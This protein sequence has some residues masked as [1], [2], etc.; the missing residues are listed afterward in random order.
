MFRPIRSYIFDIVSIILIICVSAAEALYDINRQ[1]PDINEGVLLT[2]GAGIAK[3]FIPY[4]DLFFI[5]TP[6]AY[7]WLSWIALHPSQ[8]AFAHYV[9]AVVFVLGSL[10]VFVIG[11]KIR[12]TLTGLVAALLVLSD[13]FTLIFRVQLGP[14]NWLKFFGLVTLACL[15]VWVEHHSRKWL[16]LAGAAAAAAFWSFQFGALAVIL[17]FLV[18]IWNN[19]KTRPPRIIGYQLLIA[20]AGMLIVSAPFLTYFAVNNVMG[21]FVQA[22]IG[23]PLVQNGGASGMLD[24]LLSLQSPLHPVIVANVYADLES[25]LLWPVF[26]LY[27]IYTGWRWGHNGK[28]DKSMLLIVYFSMFYLAITAYEPNFAQH[29]LPL[30]PIMEVGAAS[31]IATVFE[32][33]ITWLRALRIHPSHIFHLRSNLIPFISG[34]LLLSIISISIVSVPSS[35]QKVQNYYKGGADVPPPS[36]V[37]YID[38]WTTPSQRI[39][40]PS[41]PLT[42]YFSERQPAIAHYF[43]CYT[44]EAV[45]ALEIGT[46]IYTRRAALVV[47]DNTS[48]NSVEL[49]IRFEVIHSG[50]YHRAAEIGRYDVYALNEPKNSTVV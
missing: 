47:I 37:A 26:W 34:I 11:R 46:A 28:S 39:I 21:Q 27:L 25:K 45:E 20:L 31:L 13:L 8:L 18:I 44:T 5:H 29:T 35:I 33:E 43:H 16:M 30:I 19:F 14:E 10:T 22:V 50:A 6:F 2:A 9:E 40:V 12:N 4:K 48:G 23:V 1:V 24:R 49:A 3:G 42:Y 38:R 36:L 32:R 17:V 7:F 15:L 41:S